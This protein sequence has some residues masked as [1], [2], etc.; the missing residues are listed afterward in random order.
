MPNVR[1]GALSFLLAA[2]NPD[3]GWGYGGGASWTEPTAYALLA[4]VS[5]AAAAQN[6]ARGR[7]WL[8]ALQRPD[9][10]WPPCASV[11]QSTWVTALA[12]LVLPGE[13]G[14][15]R[16]RACQWLLEQTGRESGVLQ[17]LRQSLLGVKSYQDLRYDGWPWFPGTA[18]WVAPT[19]LVILAL[20]KAARQGVGTSPA[21]RLE[22]GRLFLWSRVC[23]DGGWNHGSTRALGYDSN[24]YPETTG[25]ALLGLHGAAA[26]ESGAAI[27]AAER[28]LSSCRSVEG[29]SWLRLGLLAHSRP[30]AVATPDSLAFR[31][32]MDHALWL[33][34]DRAASGSNAFL[35]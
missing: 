14:A 25:V 17:Q 33:L 32:V 7:R 19:A 5:E 31:G 1:P 30:V 3:G 27:A 10:G 9:G 34:A 28:H 16:Q 11:S 2:Q 24:S 26:P 20:E 15:A 29:V 4:L 21:K 35:E 23:R 12:L 8:S 6:V 13:A 22:S 18:A